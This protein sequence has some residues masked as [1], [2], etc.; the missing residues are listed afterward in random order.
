MS[1]YKDCNFEVKDTGIRCMYTNACSL[2][3]KVTELRQRADNF[4]LMGI[5]ETWATA[6]MKDAELAIKGFNMFT[7]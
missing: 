6:D 5:T 1:N 3:G 2:I 7:V 4:D